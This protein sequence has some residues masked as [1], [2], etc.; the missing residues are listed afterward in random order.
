MSENT[1]TWFQHD[2]QLST[3]LPSLTVTTSSISASFGGSISSSDIIGMSCTD[4][5]TFKKTYNYR[6][7]TT[8]TLDSITSLYSTVIPSA[9]LVNGVIEWPS[10]ITVEM[11]VYCDQIIT[12]VIRRQEQ[13]F[14]IAI[15]CPTAG[16]RN[17]LSPIVDSAINNHP[18]GLIINGIET[19]PLIFQ[20]IHEDDTESEAHLWR[21]DYIYRVDYPTINETPMSPI[22]IIDI[23]TKLNPSPGPAPIPDPDPGHHTIIGPLKGTLFITD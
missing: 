7:S 8:D 1:T 21:R 18:F 10:S 14:R 5:Y 4:K 17:S 2:Y 15:W 3:L 22:I 11:A 16:L 13:R 12:R 20:G 9:S 19:G 6:P 23:T